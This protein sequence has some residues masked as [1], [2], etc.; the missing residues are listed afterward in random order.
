MSESQQAT[1][2]SAGEGVAER[3]VRVL[4]SRVRVSRSRLGHTLTTEN[5][6]ESPRL[7]SWGESVIWKAIHG[8]LPAGCSMLQITLLNSFHSLH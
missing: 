2:E 5:R 4:W 1:I 8:I 6:G 3:S 7:Q